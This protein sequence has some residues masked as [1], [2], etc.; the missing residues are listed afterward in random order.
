MA[1]LTLDGCCAVFAQRG[2]IRSASFFLLHRLVKA[3]A[4][5]GAVA[6]AIAVSGA[7]VE[8]GNQVGLILDRD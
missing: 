3:V 6:I 5:S 4:V 2:R 7:A 1:V 8:P